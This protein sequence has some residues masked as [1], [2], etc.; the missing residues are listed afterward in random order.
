MHYYYCSLTSRWIL[1]QQHTTNANITSIS[2]Q[3][4]EMVRIKDSLL[5][6]LSQ[7][8]LDVVEG[9]STILIPSK[10]LIGGSGDA[11]LQRLRVCGQVRYESSEPIHST[12]KLPKLTQCSRNL[13]LFKHSQLDR[14]RCNTFVRQAMTQVCDRSPE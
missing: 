10:M 4:C 12:N 7:N 3:E 5:S 11:C 14:I 2:P 1:L 8:L 9:S 13:K 6:D